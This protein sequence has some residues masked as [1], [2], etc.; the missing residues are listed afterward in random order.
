MLHAGIAVARGGFT[1]GDVKCPEGDVLYA[2]LEDNQRRL[3]DRMQK[4][5]GREPWPAKLALLCSMPRLKEGGID[6]VRRWIKQAPNPRMVIIDTLA[7]VRDVKGRDQTGYEADYAAVAELQKLAGDCGVA[8]VLVHHQRKMEAE[9]RSIRSARPPAL[10]ALWIR[11][12]C[13]SLTARARG[14]TGAGGTWR[15]STRL[16]SSPSQRASGGCSGRP[17]AC[18]NP[19]SAARSSRRFRTVRSPCRRRTSRQRLA[20]PPRNVRQLLFKMVKAGQVEKKG[21]ASYIVRPA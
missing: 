19:T 13:F 16:W 10:L 5:I 4:L 8:I 12:W 11:C 14:S 6:L 9:D 2:A 20:C 17:T 7:K 21:R 18:G 15:K 3:K 1:L